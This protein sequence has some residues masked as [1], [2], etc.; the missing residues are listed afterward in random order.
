M[1]S[2]GLTTGRNKLSGYPTEGLGL[3]LENTSTPKGRY[4][5]KKLE[6]TQRHKY[7]LARSS[8]IGP[9]L[10]PISCDPSHRLVR[11][12][13]PCSDT[14]SRDAS[15]MLGWYGTCGFDAAAGTARGSWGDLIPENFFPTS[16]CPSA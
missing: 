5:T 3:E 15:R 9:V 8:S 16:L 1:L 10:R 6:G 4:V 13:K 12:P 11:C 2:T 14:A 7:R